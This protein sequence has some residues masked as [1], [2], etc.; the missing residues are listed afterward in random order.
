MR[1]AD[2]TD[3]AELMATAG[4]RPSFSG[5]GWQWAIASPEG[6]AYL[7]LNTETTLVSESSD[8]L[9]LYVATV[10]DGQSLDSQVESFGTVLDSAGQHRVVE[11]PNVPANVKPLT[12]WGIAVSKMAPAPP[13]EVRTPEEP[14]AP[15]ATRRCM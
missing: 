15:A 7:E 11:S 1:V 12:D 2:V 5:G 9:S 14:T 6:I 3:I 4:T 13:L 10:P 8:T